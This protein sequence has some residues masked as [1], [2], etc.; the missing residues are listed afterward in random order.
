MAHGVHVILQVTLP[1]IGQDDASQFAIASKVETSISGKHQQPGHV[2]PADLF[3]QGKSFS[4]ISYTITR[5]SYLVTDKMNKQSLNTTQGETLE[6]RFTS[7]TATCMM[8]S[9]P[10]SGESKFPEICC[11]LTKRLNSSP[12]SVSFKTFL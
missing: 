10:P 9:K 5:H 8:A 12:L 6:C 2:P 4:V 1:I 11:W 3:L 7:Q